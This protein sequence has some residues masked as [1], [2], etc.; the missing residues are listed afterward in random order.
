MDEEVDV[1]ERMKRKRRWIKRRRM[2]PKDRNIIG[3][4]CKIWLNL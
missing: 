3:P 2:I 4:L 1:E